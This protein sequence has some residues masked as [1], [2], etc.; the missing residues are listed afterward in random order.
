M[1]VHNKIRVSFKTIVLIIAGCILVLALVQKA[2]S[3]SSNSWLKNLFAW[4]PPTSTDQTLP[5]VK[6]KI[7]TEE[8]V[9]IDVVKSSLPS[10]VTIG[11]KVTRQGRGMN[12][13]P[14]DPFSMRRTQPE[15]E[16]IEQN[17]GSGFIVTTDGIII[18]NKHVVLEHDA[19]YTVI[20]NDKKTYD[21]T[22]IYRDPLNDLAIPKI[23][24]KN[25]NPLELGDSDKLQL[26][27][28]A[29]AIG[30]PLGEF[31]NT[32][33]SG[34]ISGLGRGITAGSPYE[35]FVEQLDSVFK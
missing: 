32:I 16:T 33:T 15:D 11:I 2:E 34:I 20:T 10:V 13:D 5:D 19:T 22:N 28:L 3:T 6:Q 17:I 27:Q 1:T 7:V 9:V 24:A 31:Q 26:G 8:S 14:F 25:L 4:K 23:D 21:L 29:V 12:Y 18:T 35:G 30:T